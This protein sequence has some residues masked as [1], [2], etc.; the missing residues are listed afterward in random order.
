MET[1]DELKQKSKKVKETIFDILSEFND[2]YINQKSKE[3]F[4]EKNYIV[5]LT[6]MLLI[7]P[8]CDDIL[9]LARKIEDFEKLK[10][11]ENIGAKKNRRK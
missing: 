9:S 2:R 6:T 5:W 4:V 11:Q 10:K 7:M 3:D 1:L 8:L